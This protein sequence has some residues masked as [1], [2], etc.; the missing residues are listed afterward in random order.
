MIERKTY[1][2]PF[3]SILTDKFNI[4]NTPFIIFNRL[5]INLEHVAARQRII[6]FIRACQ[7]LTGL[8]INLDEY[9][10]DGSRWFRLGNSV[11]KCFDVNFVNEANVNMV[12]FYETIFFVMLGEIVVECVVSSIEFQQRSSRILWS[13]N[14]LKQ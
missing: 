3:A 4:Q 5:E 11:D 1:P 2:L 6:F 8:V 13:T 7:K 12:Y 14:P 9:V 10:V